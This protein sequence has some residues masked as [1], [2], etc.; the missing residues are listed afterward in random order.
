MSKYDSL[1]AVH[2]A[3]HGDVGKLFL[4]STVLEQGTLPEYRDELTNWGNSIAEDG[5]IL[6]YGCDVAANLAGAEFVKELSDYTQ[7]DIQ[8]SDDK[9]GS[10]ELSGDWD[11]E[12]TTGN[13][14]AESVFSDETHIA[15]S[16]VLNDIPLNSNGSYF[17]DA[18][19]DKV[20]TLPNVDNDFQTP[21]RVEF[22]KLIYTNTFTTPESNFVDFDPSFFDS[23]LRLDYT[24]TGFRTV[25][26]END[27]NLSI[28]DFP[29]TENQPFSL[30]FGEPI[31]SI[32]LE[33]PDY[34]YDI[35]DKNSFLHPFDASALNFNAY[36]YEFTSVSLNEFDTIESIHDSITFKFDSGAF[37][38]SSVT[39]NDL[40]QF[41]LDKR[42]YDFYGIQYD[43]IVRISDNLL[44]D[45]TAVT[46]RSNSVTFDYK[47]ETLYFNPGFFA[48]NANLYEYKLSEDNFR[49]GV[50]IEQFNASDYRALNYAFKGD[51]LF[52]SGYY[53]NH[54]ATPDGMNPFTDYTENGWK[55]GLDPHPLFDVDYYLTNNSDVLAFGAEPLKHFSTIGHT[56]DHMNRD[57]NGIFD[58][59]YYNAN[60]PDVL[61]AGMVSLHHYVVFGDSENHDNRDPNEFFDNSYYNFSNPDVAAHPMTAVEHWMNYGYIESRP[62]NPNFNPN[63]NTHPFLNSADYYTYND[64]VRIASYASP[65]VN[66]NQ[67][68]RNHGL[69]E[70]RI[71]HEI[72]ASQN[73]AAF[74]TVIDA[75]SEGFEFVQND[76]NRYGVRAFPQDDGK[77]LISQVGSEGGISVENIVWTVFT[78]VTYRLLEN[79]LPGTL[80]KLWELQ[81]DRAFSSY[82]FNF[83]GET[84]AG[85]DNIFV[86]PGTTEGEIRVESFPGNTTINEILGSNADNVFWTPLEPVNETADNTESF[87]QRDVVL[88]G[89]LNGGIFL[90][91]EEVPQ[92]TYVLAS[93]VIVEGTP[94][95]PEELPQGVRL[96]QLE[97]GGTIRFLGGNSQGIEGY[98]TPSGE[99]REKPFSLKRSNNVGRKVNLIPIINDNGVQIQNAGI[100]DPVLLRIEVTQFG[101]EEIKNFVDNGPIKNI[102]LE[103]IFE[104]IY[105]DTADGTVVVN[106]TGTFILQK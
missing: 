84:V 32:Y 27:P 16:Y 8:A 50:T 21:S 60:N 42:V 53:L 18:T 35:T 37:D 82:S 40:L 46:F 52:D 9:T 85:N 1:D 87:P 23:G 81:N 77:I 96:G 6:L 67:H 36:D 72:F 3:S 65:S 38:F 29:Q 76:L 20:I 89:L 15:Y 24:P 44:F 103:G 73:Q 101:A 19:F 12:F 5:D 106:S 33:D 7:A 2:I 11:L 10:S 57:P 28:I 43:N 61:N 93:E 75:D 59:S 79:S 92:G 86:S 34:N 64:D 74:T 17:N 99:T 98:F 105:F 26:F 95:F 62:E 63:R 54:G 68:F 102:P 94:D 14:E 31:Y 104:T 78:G 30:N 69:G 47:P 91:G 48:D 90:G 70:G 88:E 51:E 22:G 49:S 39:T 56:E 45:A 13:I 41:D 100:T 83:T 25:E 66:P 71:T 58:T 4:G 80:L 97:G 55:F